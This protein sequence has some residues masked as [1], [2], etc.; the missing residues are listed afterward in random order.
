MGSSG[1]GSSYRLN[2]SEI[3]RLREQAQARLER[4]HV[5]AE[6]N[7]FLQRQLVEINN[8]DTDKIG[9]RLDEI[10]QGLHDEVEEFERL[11]LGGSVAKHTYVDGLSDIDSLVVLTEEVVGDRKPEEMR[12]EFRD[13][14]TR[15]LNMGDVESIQV[16][17]MAVTVV[18]RDGTE[19][20]LLPAVQQGD[21]QAISSATGEEWARINPKEFSDRLTRIN[22]DQ[23]GAVV[24][25][26]KVAKAVIANLLPEDARP[27]G[28]HV[29]ALAVAAFEGYDGARTPKAMAERFFE[30]ASED[31][32]RPIRDVTGQSR[33]VDDSLGD[34][35][36]SA[37]RSLAR[38]FGQIAKRMRDSA[39]VSD[40][41]ALLGE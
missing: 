18:Y 36:S 24:P 34:A 8:R 16:G 40:W 32:L 30:A 6:V 29:E 23:A 27:S 20:Q 26:I 19:I 3:S 25:G 2:E 12:E 7:A 17:R 39:S 1:S 28:Y 22:H 21:S 33:F 13:L 38:R 10:E 9:R 5:D 15:H 4:S 14:L 41:Q 35:G 37:R 11:L 31:V